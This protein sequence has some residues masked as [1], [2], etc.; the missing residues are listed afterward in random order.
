MIKL[1]VSPTGTPSH[2]FDAIAINTLTLQ[3]IQNRL[4]MTSFGAQNQHPRSINRF[5]NLCPESQNLFVDFAEVVQA[6]ER[7]VA[8]RLR[9]Q[10]IDGCFRLERF[11]APERISKANR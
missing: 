7:E 5:K 8:A 11:Q 4:S 2:Q 9:R 10:R 6:A 3:Q 1:Q